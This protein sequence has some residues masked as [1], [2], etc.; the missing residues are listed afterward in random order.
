MPPQ[1]QSPSGDFP[2]ALGWN[3]GI[4]WGRNTS[5]LISAGAVE[6]HD[7]A[8]D[9]W[10]RRAAVSLGWPASFPSQGEGHSAPHRLWIQLL[11]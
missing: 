6:C 8:G 5:A 1:A 4:L 7:L 11:F 10:M 3:P 9:A 2:S